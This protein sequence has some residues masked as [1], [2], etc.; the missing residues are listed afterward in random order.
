MWT[1]DQRESSDACVTLQ[2]HLCT[3]SASAACPD[4]KKFRLVKMGWMAVGAQCELFVSVLGCRSMSLCD[5]DASVGQ[6]GMFGSGIMWQSDCILSL[7]PQRVFV[8]PN[9]K[10]LRLFEI[11]VVTVI[12]CMCTVLL[13][14]FWPCRVMYET[15]RSYHSCLPC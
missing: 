12:G 6:H 4:A 11:A 3:L 10:V 5:R 9:A 13:P 14:V 7:V 2:A 15:V 8:G 1:S